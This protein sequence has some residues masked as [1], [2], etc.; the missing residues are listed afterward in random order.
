[1]HHPILRAALAG[2]R[3]NL[4]PG[5]VLWVV[6]LGIVLAYYAVPAL[7]PWFDGIEHAKQAGGY[8]FSG[9]SSAVAGAL[10]PFAGMA[11]LG[12]LPARGRGALLVFLI[13]LWSYRGMEVD[14]FYRLQAVLF[15][16]GADVATVVKKVAFDQFVYSALWTGPTSMLLYRWKDCGFSWSATRAS[17]DRAFWRVQMPAVVMSLWSVWI[18]AVSIIYCLPTSLQFPLF[19]LVL[20]FWVLLLEAVATRSQPQVLPIAA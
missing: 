17:L 14:A 10:L 12:R 20:C 11:L 5:A 2:M 7:R 1:V 13:V 4:L 16:A 8:W 15:G 19:S 6:S 18:P 3:Q 9:I